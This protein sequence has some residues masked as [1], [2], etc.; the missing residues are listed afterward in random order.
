MPDQEASLR[1]I[2]SLNEALDPT[3]HSTPLCAWACWVL[4]TWTWDLPLKGTLSSLRQEN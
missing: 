2:K 3:A 4:G 1:A